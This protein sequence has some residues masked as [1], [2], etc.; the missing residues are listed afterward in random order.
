[1][2]INAPFFLLKKAKQNETSSL[3]KSIVLHVKLFNKCWSKSFIKNVTFDI[4][5]Q[6]QRVKEFYKN[7]LFDIMKQGGRKKYNY[8]CDNFIG[9]N[10]RI[11]KHSIRPASFFQKWDQILQKDNNIV[12]KLKLPKF[13]LFIK[14]HTVEPRDNEWTSD[15]QNMFNPYNKVS[16]YSS[17]RDFVVSPPPP[18]PQSPV[19]NLS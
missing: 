16:L 19:C 3:L 6:D 4:V 18:S 10:L 17:H 1:M 2:H 12:S 14:I 8:S 9:N 15:W 5:K 13:V 11:H 7:V